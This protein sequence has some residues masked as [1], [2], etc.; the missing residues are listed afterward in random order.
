MVDETLARTHGRDIFAGVRATMDGGHGL[1]NPAHLEPP[2]AD[3]LQ[4]TLASRRWL[5]CAFCGLGHTYIGQGVW[6]DGGRCLKE[7][8]LAVLALSC[9]CFCNGSYSHHLLPTIV[10]VDDIWGC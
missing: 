9:F 3:G 10:L 7:R 6:Q 2:F 8:R 5:I 1:F 4:T